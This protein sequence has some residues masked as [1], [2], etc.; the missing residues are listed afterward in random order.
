VI[1]QLSYG[2]Q[3]FSTVKVDNSAFNPNDRLT[4]N[5]TG[6]DYSS[7]ACAQVRGGYAIASGAGTYQRIEHAIRLGL[8]YEIQ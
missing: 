4:C 8:R 1:V 7:P 5:D 6:N 3:V 2:L